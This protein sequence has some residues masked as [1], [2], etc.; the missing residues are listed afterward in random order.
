MPGADQYVSL[1]ATRGPQRSVT[2][3][4]VSASHAGLVQSLV[5]K[6]EAKMLH[7]MRLLGHVLL[8]R[9]KLERPPLHTMNVIQV[10]IISSGYCAGFEMS[11]P[12][13]LNFGRVTFWRVNYTTAATKHP[14]RDVVS[15]LRLSMATQTTVCHVMLTIPLRPRAT[16]ATKTQAAQTAAGSKRERGDKGAHGTREGGAQRNSE[17]REVRLL[18]V[19]STAT[20]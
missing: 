17:E 14:L 9:L 15:K 2:A 11:A 16:F 5:R 1:A 6:C 4:C 18:L 8:P 7:V 12:V 20:R 3:A 19:Y 10:S 13:G